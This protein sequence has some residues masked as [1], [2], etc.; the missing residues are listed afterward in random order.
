V[1]LGAFASLLGS[2]TLVAR[3]GDMRR[4]RHYALTSAEQAFAE[5]LVESGRYATIEEVIQEG[6]RLL[7]EE[8]QTEPLDLATVQRLWR[9]GALDGDLKPASEVLDRLQAKYDALA[10]DRSR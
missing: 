10:R 3:D 7:R 4:T 8:E 6:L 1:T 9:E 5:Q 2:T